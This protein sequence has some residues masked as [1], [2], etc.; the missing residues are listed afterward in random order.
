MAQEVYKIGLRK[1][2]RVVVYRE[3]DGLVVVRVPCEHTPRKPREVDVTAECT[4]ELRK[5]KSSGG[6]YVGIIH[7]GSVVFALG[8]DEKSKSIPFGNGR[9][10]LEHSPDA[11]VSFRVKRR[12]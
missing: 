8:V 5:S 6:Y 2:E 1:G 9:Y 10:T 7:E 3:A 11:T 4:A 12:G